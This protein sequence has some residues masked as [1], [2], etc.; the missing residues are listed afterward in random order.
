MKHEGTAYV[1]MDGGRESSK[2]GILQSTAR[3]YGYTGDIRS[4]TKAQAE[5]IYNRF[6]SNQEPVPCL[7][8]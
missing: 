2:M 1:R 3:Q 5:A 6:G 4:I 8:H 7:I